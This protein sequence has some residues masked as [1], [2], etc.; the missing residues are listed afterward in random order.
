MTDSTTSTVAV[1]LDVH[2]ASIRLAAVRADE[3]LAERTLDN[4]HA[5]VERE[6]TRWPGARC[7]YEA[8]T[9]GFGL[10]RHLTAAGIA[11]DVVAPGS[12]RSGRASASRPIH[13]MRASSR[14][15]TPAGCS[16]RSA[17]RRSRSRRCATSC[18]RRRV[19]PRAR[20]VRLGDRD[21]PAAQERSLSSEQSPRPRAADEPDHKENPRDHYAAPAVPAAGDPRD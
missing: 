15:F 4:D 14:A 3:L 18:A 9:T 17:C 10:H 7:R 19:R 5:A 13:A 21:R 2:A 11:C 20:G 1:G 12:C 8:G 16:S 6:L